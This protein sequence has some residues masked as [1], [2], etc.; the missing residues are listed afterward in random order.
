MYLKPRLTYQQWPS[1]F[2][3]SFNFLLS[4]FCFLNFSCCPI[5]LQLKLRCL[6]RQSLP[7]LLMKRLRNYLH[8]RLNPL[9]MGDQNV[10]HGWKHM[11][12]MESYK[13]WQLFI[14]LVDL[15]SYWDHGR[16]IVHFWVPAKTQVWTSFFHI[17]QITTTQCMLNCNGTSHS[18][19]KNTLRQASLFQ[20]C[21]AWSTRGG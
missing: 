14:T 21:D 8:S 2:R 7:W 18:A 17:S 4:I 3:L 12:H 19:F 1:Y 11:E 5:F 13:M 20:V 6:K 9:I 16:P 15:G 10:E